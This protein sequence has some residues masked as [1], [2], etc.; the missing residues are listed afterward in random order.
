M[1]YLMVDYY[2]LSIQLYTASNLQF[3]IFV[4]FNFMFL[5]NPNWM[6]TNENKSGKGL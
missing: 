4:Q 1:I 2:S 6:Y 3:Y 5:N